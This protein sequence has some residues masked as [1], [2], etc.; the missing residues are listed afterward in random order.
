MA[1]NRLVDNNSF[2]LDDMAFH[3]RGDSFLDMPATTAASIL[4]V[5]VVFWLRRSEASTGPTD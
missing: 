2:D 5:R 3:D 1:C 4:A